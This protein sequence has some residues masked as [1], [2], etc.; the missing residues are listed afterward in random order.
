M[1]R[2]ALFA[3]V[4]LSALALTACGGG[5]DTADGGDGDAAPA[6]TAT[7]VADDIVFSDAPSSLP[8]GQVEVTLENVGALEHTL[9]F[10]G[11]NGGAPVLE[12]TPGETLSG[13]VDL[14]AGEVT[15]FCTIAGHREA[16]MEGTIQV[17]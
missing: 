16:G 3:A 7:F 5:G 13:T 10:E 15:F 11:I 14:P 17:G 2:S 4:A 9:A 1:T 6:A 8:A 12:S